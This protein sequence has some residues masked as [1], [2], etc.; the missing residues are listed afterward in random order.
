MAVT[1]SLQVSHELEICKNLECNK[2]SVM[3]SKK[4]NLLKA[5]FS[6]VALQ[7]DPRRIHLS[8]SLRKPICSI[9]FKH[10]MFKCYSLLNPGKVSEISC[11]KNAAIAFTRSYNAFQGS[12]IVL[13][14]V[15]AVG[16]IVVAIWGLGPLMRQGRSV[17]FH[18]NDSSWKKSG[19]YYVMTSYLQPLLLWTGATLICRVL[20]PMVLPSEASEIVKQRLLNFIRSLSTVLA[21]AYCLSSVIQQAQKFFMETNDTTDPRNMGFQ[22]AGKAVYTAVWVAAVSLFMELLG[23][24]TQ[25]WL[26]AGGLGTVLLTLA[27]REIFTNFLSS[28]M[29]HATRPFVVNEWIQTKIEGYEVSGTVEHV[30]WWSPTIVRGE[31]REAVH[32]PNHKFT[33]NVVRNL[34]QKTHWRIKTHLAV[35]HLDV[36]KINNIVADMRKVLAKNPHVEHKKL[37]RRV[38][39]DNINPENQAL[40][41]LISCFVKTSHF[42]EYLCV[43]E[44]ILLDLLRVISHHRARLATPIRTIQKIYSDPD[45]ENIPF[46]DSIFTRG[47][48]AASN[49]P[50]LLIEPHYKIN[51]EDR[52]KTQTRSMRANGEQ[53]DSKP[54][55]RP[56][57]N[58]KTDAKGGGATLLSDSKAKETHPSSDSRAREVQTSGMKAGE[59]QNSDSKGDNT[60]VASTSTSTST[61]GRKVGDKVMAKSTS[62]SASKTDSKFAEVSSSNSK[63]VGSTSTQNISNNK[64]P[65]KTGLGNTRQSSAASFSHTGGQKLGDYPSSSQSSKQESERLTQA[66]PISRPPLEEN[67]VLGVALEGSK[68]TL[69]IEEGMAPSPSPSPSPSSSPSP[70]PTQAEVKELATCQNGNGSVVVDQQLDKK[71]GQLPNTPSTMSGDQQ[72]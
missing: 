24:S 12:P 30:G 66:P 47:G 29:I 2:L 25:K 9:Q 50:L 65:E 61:P 3:R 6:S 58:G 27:G 44:A 39:L 56:T 19:T 22:F 17:F 42:E 70:S 45:L 40:L 55:V 37:H 68:R 69:P 62:T 35:S 10:N 31:D 23:F 59:M 16:I 54:A 36:N 15:S 7:Q 8:G 4:L 67:I 13:K 46:S 1:G 41:I 33:V 48:A 18:K 34:T 72:G 51:G 38:F 43:K 53:Q 52:T 32:I 28:A 14:L 20:D 60:A 5:N 63:A 11:M 64:Q 49:R 57:S 26:T 71:D 21:L